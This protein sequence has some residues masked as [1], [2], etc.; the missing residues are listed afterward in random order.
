MTLLVSISI[1]GYNIFIDS[2]RICVANVITGNW[3]IDGTNNVM[4]GKTDQTISRVMTQRININLV[5]RQL[6]RASFDRT[7]ASAWLCKCITC[8]QNKPSTSM[9]QVAR[10]S[11]LLSVAGSGTCGCIHAQETGW[12]SVNYKGLVAHAFSAGIKCR[13]CNCPAGSEIQNV[14]VAEHI[15]KYL[16]NIPKYVIF[17]RNITKLIM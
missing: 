2:L 16:R 4:A 15:R 5:F 10:E 1:D 3:Q 7:S 11:K 14:N 9:T 13:H 12:Q 8:Q 6:I 17:Q